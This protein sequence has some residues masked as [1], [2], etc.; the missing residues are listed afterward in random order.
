LELASRALDAKPE[1]GDDGS[2]T[3]AGYRIPS[4]VPNTMT[5]NFEGGANDVQT[6]SFADLRECVE[7]N[8][9]DFF[10]REFAGKIVILGTLL[11]SEDRKFTSKRFATGLDGSR[12]P[13]CALPPAPPAAGQF[14][15]NSI[16][17][18][19]IPAT[20]V[21]NLMAHD[22]VVEPGRLPTI[23]IA[24]AF[25]ALAALAAR[26]LAPGAAAAIYVAMVA[27]WTLSA[28]F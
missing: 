9:T 28:T 10:H 1:W 25:A 7:R 11:D 23:A 3:L 14:K 2:V 20:A 24:V 21:H 26:M 17:G 8:N 18:V 19:Y 12:A 16:A 4:A 5:L 15:R 13:R 6:F 27:I 22:A